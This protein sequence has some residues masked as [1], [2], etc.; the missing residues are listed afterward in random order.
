[1]SIVTTFTSPGLSLESIVQISSDTFRLKFTYDPLLVSAAGAN[2]ALNPNNYT[3]SGPTT[4][5]ISSVSIVGGDS[6]SVFLITNVPLTTG[7]WTITAANIQTATASPLVQPKSLSFDVSLVTTNPSPTPGSENDDAESILR[8]HLNPALVGPG[9]NALIAGIAS[10]DQ[11]LF[12]TAKAAFNQMFRSTASGKYL[13]RRASDYGFRRPKGVGVADDVF[14]ELAIKISAEKLTLNS[15]LSVLEIYYGADATRASLDSALAQTY[16]ISE[17]D[18]LILSIDGQIVTIVFHTVN[19]DSPSAA[20]ATEIASV[21]TNF[22]E[23]NS[24]KSYAIP[25]FDTTIQNYKVRIYSGALGLRGRIQVLGGKAQN[26]LQFPTILTTTQDVG[27]Q[28]QVDVPATLPT[29]IADRSR[30]TWI[31]GTDPSLQLV[32]IGDYANIYGDPFSADNR[33][34]LSVVGISDT[35][36]E[37]VNTTAAAQ[38]ATQ[39]TVNDILFFRP[40]AYTINNKSRFSTATEGS[41]DAVDVTL[42]ATTQAVNRSKGTGAYLNGNTAFKVVPSQS[43]DA[44]RS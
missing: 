14:R 7:T 35:Y 33:G 27:T 34:A 9:W 41:L 42:S 38:T 23:L 12:D 11:H 20:T 36:F 17:G 22:L 18:D 30:Y 6:A 28:W 25:V 13:D 19:F 43:V 5:N 1:M 16:K 39:L 37:V 26:I 29:L 8:K 4:A 31:G 24:L 15:F 44:G 10:G 3:L 2:D 21:I 32:R 40:S